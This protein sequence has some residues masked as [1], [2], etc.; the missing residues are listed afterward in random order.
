MS[1]SGLILG[2]LC[3]AASLTP[4]LVPRAGVVQGALAGACFA[5]GYGVAVLA[6]LIWRGLGLPVLRAERLRLPAAGIALAIVGWALIRAPQGQDALHRV[7]NLPPVETVRPLSIALTALAV[8]GVLLA[9]GVLF[10]RAALAVSGRLRIILPERLALLLGVVIVLMLFNFIGN[11]L[12]LRQAIGAFD[13][14][15]QRIDAALPSTDPMKTGSLIRWEDLGAEGRNRISDP[16]DAVGIAAITGRPAREPLR[17]YVGLGSGETPDDRARLALEEAIRT[18]AF[19]RR[20]LV[21]ATPTGTGWVD[22]AAMFPLEVLTR[23]DVATVSVQYS[24]LPSWLS[25]LTVPEYGEETARA[26]FAAIHDH[27]RSLPRDS[28]PKLYLFGLSLGALNSDLSADFYDLIADP[29]Q[30]ALWVGPPFGSRSWRHITEDRAPGSPEWLPRFRDGSVVR[31]LNQ[32]GGDEGAPWGPVRIVYLQYASDPITFFS[33][34][35]LWREPDWMRGPRGPDVAPELRW[36]PVV[37][38]LQVGFDVMT[39]TTTPRGHGHVYA[40]VDYLNGW[41]ALLS[42]EGWSEA[43]LDRLRAAMAAREL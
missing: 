2:A 13:A 5:T 30:G 20:T 31:F 26:V 27:W 14:S 24:Y 33:P 21:I 41:L 38:F 29:Y 32:N 18:G 25:L 12:L 11:D 15:Y 23:G 43:A 34:S 37:T 4:S 6:G 3:L 9:L 8:A 19:T 22:P 1:P 39:A 35:M 10:H 28:R 17:I 42:P 16:L 7:M 40:G 36:I